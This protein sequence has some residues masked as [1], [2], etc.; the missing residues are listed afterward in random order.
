MFHPSYNINRRKK[1][2][3]IFENLEMCVCVCVWGGGGGGGGGD[4]Y[5]HIIQDPFPCKCI[6]YRISNMCLYQKYTYYFTRN[7]LNSAQFIW[8]KGRTT[9]RSDPITLCNCVVCVFVI[10]IFY[11][12]Q[13]ALRFSLVHPSV[14]P[15]VRHTLQYSVYVINSHS[16]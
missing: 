1:K 11:A 15:S 4:K 5:G 10:C 3:K 8:L 2:E 7:I 14:C 12:S 13:S 6:V 9:F 16:F